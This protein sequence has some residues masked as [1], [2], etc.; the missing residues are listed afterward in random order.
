LTNKFV[1]LTKCRFIYKTAARNPERLQASGFEGIKWDLIPRKRSLTVRW[2]LF[3]FH[4]IEKGTIAV[5]S[6]T[7]AS[8]NKFLGGIQAHVPIGAALICM[9]VD[10]SQTRSKSENFDQGSHRHP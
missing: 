6:Q 5:P 7:I 4:G 10:P 3:T 2:Y 9:D 8:G 1:D